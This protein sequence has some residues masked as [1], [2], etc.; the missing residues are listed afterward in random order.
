MYLLCKDPLLFPLPSSLPFSLLPFSSLFSL[1]PPLSPLLSLACFY[2]FPPPS[3]ADLLECG[4]E[5]Q[6]TELHV[7]QPATSDLLLPPPGHSQSSMVNTS[8]QD[9]LSTNEDRTLESLPSPTAHTHPGDAAFLPEVDGDEHGTSDQNASSGVSVAS[10]EVE[11]TY[12]GMQQC[13]ST[14]TSIQ[15]A[16]TSILSGVAESVHENTSGK[17]EADVSRQQSEDAPSITYTSFETDRV[18]SRQTSHESEVR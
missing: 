12:S 11:R 4:S 3:C 7:Q 18:P 13:Y 15:S 14:Q 2:L 10:A 5:T 6:V 17:A 1:S 8:S 9:T 16:E